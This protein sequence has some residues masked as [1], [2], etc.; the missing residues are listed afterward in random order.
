MDTHE[1]M[2]TCSMR[3]LL[4]SDRDRPSTKWWTALGWTSGVDC[5]VDWLER[6]LANLLSLTNPA[7]AH[8]SHS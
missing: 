1:T 5:K 2:D 4:S 6:P 3:W 8:L 7:H